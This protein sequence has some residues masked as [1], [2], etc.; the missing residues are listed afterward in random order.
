MF[1][2]WLLRQ[3]ISDALAKWLL[4][5]VETASTFRSWVLLKFMFGARMSNAQLSSLLND[6]RESLMTTADE[7][8]ATKEPRH[9]HEQDDHGDGG[10]LGWARRVMRLRTAS[11][12]HPASAATAEEVVVSQVAVLPSRDVPHV[13]GV[14]AWLTGL[15]VDL[16]QIAVLVADPHVAVLVCARRQAP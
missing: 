6:Y 10:H 3:G 1:L 11:S 16:D 9:G 12:A 4:K 8:G 5:P 7:L 14:R 13:P 15:P 2:S